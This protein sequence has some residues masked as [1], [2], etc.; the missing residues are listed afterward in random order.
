MSLAI[1]F[2]ST[3][4]CGFVIGFSKGWKLALVM[5]SVVPL[6]GISAAMLF[7]SIG[8]LTALGQSLYAEVSGFGSLPPHALV[9]D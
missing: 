8:K 7:S 2:F 3:F 5:M 1:Q 4:V 9:D 6:L